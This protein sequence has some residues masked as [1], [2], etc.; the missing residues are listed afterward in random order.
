MAHSQDNVCG[1]QSCASADN[2]PRSADTGRRLELMVFSDF[3]CPWC[4]IG[5]FR[6]DQALSLARDATVDVRW[7]P[8]ELNPTMPAE[9][10]NRR[11]YRSAKFGSWSRSLVLDAQVEQVARIEGLTFRHDLITRTP[12]TRNAHRLT[13]LAK[14][15]KKQ[16]AIGSAIL[17]AYFL[18]GRDVGQLE[19]LADIAGEQGMQRGETLLWLESDAGR[20]E[21]QQ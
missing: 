15:Q 6:L 13:W 9:G 12:N 11:E 7:M 16:D 8:F 19:V 14:E 1:S 20:H 3:I 17:R 18:E 10:M 2:P 5:K 4:L 21:V